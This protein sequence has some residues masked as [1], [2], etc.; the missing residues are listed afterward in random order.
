[1]SKP[2][3]QCWSDNPLQ[4]RALQK[5]CPGQ[6]LHV[7]TD[8]ELVYVGLMGKCEKLNRHKWGGSRGL[9]HMLICGQNYGP[10]GTGCL[11]TGF[12]HMGGYSVMRVRIAMQLKEPR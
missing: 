8:S 7:V 4:E 2:P 10:S 11:C 12:L 1:M 9:W 5:K 6:P 3:S